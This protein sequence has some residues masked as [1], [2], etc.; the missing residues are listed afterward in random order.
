[1]FSHLQA[2]QKEVNN[3][4]G[5]GD[6]NGE[7][8]K[9]HIFFRNINW[10]QLEAGLFKPPFVPDVSSFS[11]LLLFLNFL[12]SVSLYFYFGLSLYKMSQHISGALP[13]EQ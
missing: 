4:L 12:L 9:K 2:L 11:P 8:A 5:S 13:E 10:P 3:R 6:L 7:E 1:L